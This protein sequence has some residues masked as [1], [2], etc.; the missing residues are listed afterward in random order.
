MSGGSLG[1]LYAKENDRL[2]E[3]NTVEDLETAAAVLLNDGYKDIAMDVLRLA[4]YI[5][6]AKIRVTV[7]HEQLA[8]VLH[9]VEWYLSADYGKDTMRKHLDA[10]R[11]GR[12]TEED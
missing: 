9:A 7:L 10:Y 8:D 6:S 2:F 3:A 1:Y 4:E 5:K 12:P 11:A